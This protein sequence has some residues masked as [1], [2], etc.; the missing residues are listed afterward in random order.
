M[1]PLIVRQLDYDLTPVA[2]LTLVGHML[3]LPVMRYFRY[4]LKRTHRVLRPTDEPV[5]NRNQI[6]N[7][8]HSGSSQ[9]TDL[10]WCSRATPCSPG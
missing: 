8:A 6:N 1:R 10:G 2:G 4:L 7:V 3:N 5:E 9:L